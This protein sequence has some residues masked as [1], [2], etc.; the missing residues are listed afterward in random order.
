VN[1]NLSLFQKLT[2]DDVIASPFPHIVLNHALPDLLHEQLRHDFPA[3]ENLGVNSTLNNHRYSIKAKDLPSAAAIKSIWRDF[4]SYH[5]SRAFFN[6]VIRV[7]GE[8]IC[9]LYP[10]E[11]PRSDTLLKLPVSLRD[12]TALP[13]RGFALDAQVSG[14]TPAETPGIPRG[15]HNDA[16]NALWAGLYYLRAP[17]DNSTGG[18]LQIWKWKNS[19]NYRKKSSVYKEDVDRRHVELLKTIP[20]ESN[21]LVF[22]INSLDSLHSVTEREATKHS[23]QFVNLVCDRKAP[24]FDLKPYTH[25]RVTRFIRRALVD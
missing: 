9:S 11:F 1:T 12:L 2:K 14:N 25:T 19:L 22:F 16:P 10:R 3:L 20:Y 23:R 5:S 24:F 7:F 21:T 18:D 17:N 8:S 6:D 15:I 4:I 13:E